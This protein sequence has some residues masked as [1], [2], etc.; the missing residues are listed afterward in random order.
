MLKLTIITVVFNGVSS[1]KDTLDNVL[2]LAIDNLSYIVVDGNSTDGT[3][4]ILKEYEFKF[5]S[6]GIRYNWKSESDKG[7]Y[8]AMNKGWN[9]AEDEAFILFLGSGD[10]IL[11]VPDYNKFE[12]AD[13]LFG[14][15]MAGDYLFNSKL[16]FRLR[17]GNMLHHQ[18]LFVRKSTY[19]NSPFDIKYKV[20]AD[21][22]FNQRLLIEGR[23]FVKDDN[24][25]GYAL[26]GGVSAVYNYKEAYH[27]IHKNF[28]A[29]YVILA[30]IYY[31][32][33]RNFRAK[34]S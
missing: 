5:K 15:V 9:M 23:R 20:Y 31:F 19:I 6:K 28:G 34:K 32:L 7:L 18:A 12:N 8:D 33:Q 25:L 29:H 24:F 17:L 16:D 13:V 10:K 3:V 1:I 2:G 21:F 26:E 27:I 22:D 30:K 11:Q 14:N 4:E